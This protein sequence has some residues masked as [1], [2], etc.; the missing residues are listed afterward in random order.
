MGI[1]KIIITR[2]LLY[3]HQHEKLVTQHLLILV[4]Q[5]PQIQKHYDEQRT[6][7]YRLFILMRGWL[8]IRCHIGIHQELSHSLMFPIQQMKQHAIVVL[9]FNNL[10]HHYSHY[11]NLIL[12]IHYLCKN[13]I[14][15]QSNPYTIIVNT[16]LIKEKEAIMWFLYLL[17]TV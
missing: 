17:F 1:I 2:Q 7:K 10:N 13:K 3:Q 8:F 5:D 15:I 14:Y 9:L 16:H 11:A 6:V 12:I 4:Y